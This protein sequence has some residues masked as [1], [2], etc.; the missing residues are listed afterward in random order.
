MGE[1]NI[2]WNSVWIFKGVR[3][4]W[5]VLTP[6]DLDGVFFNHVLKQVSKFCGLWNWPSARGWVDSDHLW[7]GKDLSDFI[8]SYV[9]FA[10]WHCT[11]PAVYSL[12]SS[13]GRWSRREPA[14]TRGSWGT[15]S[16]HS[17][18]EWHTAEGTW[19]AGSCKQSQ[20]VNDDIK[21]MFGNL[22]ISEQCLQQ[23]VTE[24]IRVQSPEVW[25]VP[26]ENSYLWI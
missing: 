3:R 2:F 13:R 12:W 20:V 5:S 14:R 10:S 18:T 25:G 17:R 24:S 7:P 19:P 9:L 15:L 22:S 26:P 8:P 4:R 1:N 16:I 6:D 11:S 21:T 23:N